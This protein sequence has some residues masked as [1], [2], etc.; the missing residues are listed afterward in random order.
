MSNQTSL[1][2][3]K[4]INKLLNKLAMAEYSQTVLETQVEELT[5]KN[6]KLKEQGKNKEAK[7]A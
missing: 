6:K 2:A 1:D 7:E 4:V 3:N 5:E